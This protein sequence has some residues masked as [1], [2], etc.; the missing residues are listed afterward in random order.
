MYLDKLIQEMTEKKDKLE[1]YIKIFNLMQGHNSQIRCFDHSN[2]LTI[3]CQTER[4]ALC[5][6]C[7]YGINRHRTHRLLPLKDATA[8]ITEDNMLLW[9]QINED[10]R[11][12]DES[13]KSSQD[14]TLL[15]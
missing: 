5:A 12:M 15:L 2:V 10:L 1:R 8:L 11:K 14:N 13:I 3:Y 6:N 7:V 9:T 4:K